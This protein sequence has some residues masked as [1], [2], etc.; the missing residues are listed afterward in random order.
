MKSAYTSKYRAHGSVKIRHWNCI[1]TFFT[2]FGM[3]FAES[4]KKKIPGTALTRDFRGD[5][6]SG[7]G[8]HGRK[9]K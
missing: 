1:S 7:I 8:G 4:G 5:G 2:F 3:V 9:L 6:H